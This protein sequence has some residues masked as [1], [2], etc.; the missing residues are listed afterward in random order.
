MFPIR[1]PLVGELI[2]DIMLGGFLSPFY[3]YQNDDG[4]VVESRISA[5]FC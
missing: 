3:L 2:H 1:S 5:L 4:G